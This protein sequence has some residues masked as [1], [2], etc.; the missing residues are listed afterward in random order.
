MSCDHLAELYNFDLRFAENN[1]PSLF[2]FDQS[3]RFELFI[4]LEW[5]G[6]ERAP[7]SALRSHGPYISS[8]NLAPMSSGRAHFLRA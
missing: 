1:Y 7:A 6:V 5:H 2:I 8:K 3:L 4:P